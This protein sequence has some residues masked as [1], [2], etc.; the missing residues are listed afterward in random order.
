M[1]RRRAFWERV[2]RSG[3]DDACW[4]WM[5]ARTDK[6]YGRFCHNAV[7]TAANREVLA[8]Q[9]ELGSDMFG[10][11][12]CNNPSCCNPR[13]LYAGTRLDNARDMVVA[14]RAN[15]ARAPGPVATARRM[16]DG[17][18]E[19]WLGLRYVSPNLRFGA[20]VECDGTGWHSETVRMPE[21]TWY[22]GQE[23]T[24]TFPCQACCGSGL[25]QGA[26]AFPLGDD[27]WRAG[28]YDRAR[29]WTA[30]RVSADPEDSWVRFRGNFWT[31]Y[32]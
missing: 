31:G 6:G 29:P 8:H 11:H 26:K 5:G 12:R 30:M 23:V 9:G 2:D 17:E 28:V 1:C 15:G 25:G 3:G 32:L 16:D 10:C 19:D 7:A 20:C 4:P 18:G 14:G 24:S 13:H 22:G 27:D 21:G